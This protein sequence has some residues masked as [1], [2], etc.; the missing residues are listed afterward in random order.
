MAD[1]AFYYKAFRFV[2][3][4]GSFSTQDFRE[5]FSSRAYL[6]QRLAACFTDDSEEK[7]F[8]AQVEVLQS[9]IKLF[10]IITHFYWMLWAINMA[11]V[12]DIDQTHSFNYF[13]YG[14]FRYQQYLKSKQHFSHLY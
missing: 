2:D 7:A 13:N 8:L 3:T 1:F 10:I 9:Q 5:S 4:R 11:K 14:L 6:E 12:S